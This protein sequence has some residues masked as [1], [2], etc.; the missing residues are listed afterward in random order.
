MKNAENLNV[1]FDF[2]LKVFF[3]SAFIYL[4]ADSIK[5]AVFI[6]AVF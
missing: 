6:R 1:S 5:H 2:N 3:S 4:E